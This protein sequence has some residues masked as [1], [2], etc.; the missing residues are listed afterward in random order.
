MITDMLFI[1]VM[2]LYSGISGRLVYAFEE[3]AVGG[4]PKNNNNDF[5][6]LF[7]KYTNSVAK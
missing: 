2:G 4:G 7:S 3:I 1:F 6:F 5:H